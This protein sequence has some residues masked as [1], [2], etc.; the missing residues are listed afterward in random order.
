MRASLCATV[1]N[2]L[3]SIDRFL[4]SIEKEPFEVVVADGGSKDGTYERLLEWARGPL[5]DRLTVIRRER[6]TSRGR[7]RQIAFDGSE[8]DIVFQLDANIEYRNLSKYLGLYSDFY[9]GK[10][11]CFGWADRP[12]DG[13]GARH[14]LIASRR[15]WNQVGGYRDLFA[16]EDV[17][18]AQRAGQAYLNLP[19]DLEDAIPLRVRGMRS[20]ESDTRRYAKGL[21]RRIIREAI[22]ARDRI[23]VGGIRRGLVEPWKNGLPRLVQKTSTAGVKT[24]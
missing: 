8:G 22:S 15:A 1:Y 7:G 24:A 20:G 5:R 13:S 10:I 11:V 19:I 23:R 9:S 21:P 2:S 6:W 16:W 3:D 12:Q 18:L 4:G 17:D 14:F